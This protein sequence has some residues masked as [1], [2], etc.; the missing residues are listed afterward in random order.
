[1]PHAVLRCMHPLLRAAQRARPLAR[2]CGTHLCQCPRPASRRRRCGWCSSLGSLHGRRG[3][4]GSSASAADEKAM[5]QGRPSNVACTP[6]RHLTCPPNQRQP[7]PRAP[8]PAGSCRL[9]AATQSRRSGPP[10]SAGRLSYQ[11]TE[12]MPAKAVAASGPCS[13]TPLPS[14]WWDGSEQEQCRRQQQWRQQQWHRRQQPASRTGSRTGGGGSGG[15]SRQRRRQRQQHQRHST[16]H[17]DSRLC[18]QQRIVR[19]PAAAAGA[20][21]DARQQRQSGSRQCSTAHQVGR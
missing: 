16:Q 13:S 20:R 4:S 18:W 15:S 12:T 8:A 19:Q 2:P 7:A 1:M 3:G 17:P 6:S 5:R 9:R 21:A 10:I 14:A 11:P